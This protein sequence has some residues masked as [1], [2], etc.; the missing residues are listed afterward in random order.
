MDS[1]DDDSLLGVRLSAMTS[2][3]TKPSTPLECSSMVHATS[4]AGVRTREL[5]VEQ[6]RA[7]RVREAHLGRGDGW[8][9]APAGHR[10][11]GRAVRPDRARLCCWLWIATLRL[12]CTVIVH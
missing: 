4:N 7:W 3:R 2:G 6:I 11:D 5:G 1:P 12:R 8:P 10:D 9:P